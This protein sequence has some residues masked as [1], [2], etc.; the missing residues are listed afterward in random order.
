MSMDKNHINMKFIVM[1][2]N[3]KNYNLSDEL[4][5]FIIH[6]NQDAQFTSKSLFN[7]VYN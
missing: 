2:P 7:L 1:K 4:T 3:F 6:G 5:L